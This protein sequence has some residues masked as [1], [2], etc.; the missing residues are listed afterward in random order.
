MRI[1]IS[2]HPTVGGSGVVATELAGAL[3]EGGDEVH[4]LS[5]ALPARWS[6]GGS[7]LFFHPVT[8]GQYPLFEYPPY[9]LALATKM[10]DVVRQ[11]RLD[12][13]HV[14][15][16]VPNA[17]S[18]I[19]AREILAPDPIRV[20][21]TLHGTDVT[22]VGN[23][24]S[25]LETTRLAIQRSD[26]VTA[27]SV[28]LRDATLEQ[29]GNGREIRVV[30]NFI[31]PQRYLDLAEGVGARSWAEEGERV[32]VHMSNFRRVKRVLDVV[33]ILERV[34]RDHPVRL[35]LVGEGPEL[36]RAEQLCREIDVSD[37]V[38][39]MGTVRDVEEVLAGADVFL[40]PSETESFGL[41]A[42]EA[43]SCEVPVVA[44][45]VGGIPEVVEDGFSGFLRPVGDIEGMAQAVDRLLRNEEE[46]LEMGRRG[47]LSAIERFRRDD[48]VKKYRD[49]YEEVLARDPAPGNR[50]SARPV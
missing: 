24:P 49:L 33:R 25:Y 18:A 5:Y 38:V 1:G 27:V 46:R 20:I 6:T 26:C 2:C 32:L 17:I 47:R 4:V 48:V 31:D 7:R 19:L 12:L 9:S 11:H 21:T 16:A 15:Y 43:L 10:V 42:L 36:P 50:F 35:L 22:L 44:S 41:A 40:L 37:R 45:R 3:A 34:A 28:S 13:L 29:L 8:V 30:P 14:H 23:D 39:F